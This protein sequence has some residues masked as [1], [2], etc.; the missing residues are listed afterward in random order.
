MPQMQTGWSPVSSSRTHRETS[1]FSAS[2]KPPGPSLHPPVRSSW[3]SLCP[4][5]SLESVLNTAA[6]NHL[7]FK[8]PLCSKSAH[9]S[10]L[11]G[12]R[13]HSLQW[14][15]AP[16]DLAWHLWV[17]VCCSA[18]GTFIPAPG[19]HHQVLPSARGD[20]P[21]RPCGPSLTG[22]PSHMAPC[23]AF[24]EEALWCSY[25]P[26]PLLLLGWTIL[27]LS[28]PGPCH[29]RPGGSRADFICI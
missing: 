29:P 23:L 22:C 10:S 18:P 15:Q 27:V 25:S 21:R 19:T 4:L 24:W 6:T 11:C 26:L 7:L 2:T 16:Q 17:P 8:S 14:P 5:P 20:P 3:H 9:G 13:A 28:R 12:E 1:G